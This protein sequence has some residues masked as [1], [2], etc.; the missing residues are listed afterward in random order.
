[1]DL[2][3]ALSSQLG[4]EPDQA[5]ALAGS[6]LGGV[7]DQIAEQA[8]PE[9]AQKM[10]AAIPELGG[11]QDMASKFLGGGASGATGSMGG[12]LGAAAG[13]MGGGGG[14]LG[15]AA[16][17]IGGP[18]A[19]QAAQIVAILGKFGVDAKMAGVAAPLVLDFLKDRLPENVLGA[20]LAAAPFLAGG[21]NDDGD[22]GGGIAGALGGLFGG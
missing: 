1:M 15:A 4:L 14:L 3:G 21:S 11:W 20:A 2:I 18:E 17:A 10:N 6:V 19:R 13:A 8:G 5:K 7:R 12:L 22:D 16:G 9:T